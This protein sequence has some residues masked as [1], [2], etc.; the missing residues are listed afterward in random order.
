VLN[1]GPLIDRT[2]QG[3]KLRAANVGVVLAI[4]VHVVPRW[5]LHRMSHREIGIYAGVS[6]V[7]AAVSLFI[8][9]GT[10][11][12]PVCGANWMWRAVKQRAGGWLE[13][14]RN[15]QVC[16]ACGWNGGQLP[17]QASGK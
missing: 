7:I 13:W 11:R 5:F 12:C 3:W 1:Y 15:Q 17:D 16:P 9:F 10:I 14:L 4:I 8:F 2:N 6:A